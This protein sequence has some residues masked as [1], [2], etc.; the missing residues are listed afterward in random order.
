LPRSTQWDFACSCWSAW[1][2]RESI[3]DQK[4]NDHTSNSRGGGHIHIGDPDSAGGCAASGDCLLPH[5][6]WRPFFRAFSSEGSFQPETEKAAPAQ[7]PDGRGVP[8]PALFALDDLP[9]AD[10]RS[11]FSGACGDA[12]HLGVFNGRGLFRGK[13]Y[14]CDVAGPFRCRAW[15]RAGW[16]SPVWGRQFE[17]GG[18]SPGP[19]GRER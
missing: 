6:F 12:A 16:F 11:Q 4:K 1:T 5:V 17:T 14:R 2:E 18:G 15:Q 19:G 10:E 13:A 9:K 7:R 8:R 3:A